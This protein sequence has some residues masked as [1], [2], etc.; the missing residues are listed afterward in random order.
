MRRFQFAI[1]VGMLAVLLSANPARAAEMLVEAE[2]LKDLGGW[3]VDQQFI[4]A[5]GSSY[6][7]AHGLGKPC[8]AAKGTVSLPEPG[9]YRVWVRTKDWVAE[10]EWAPGQFRIAINGKLLDETFGTKGDGAWIWQDGG[11]VDIAARDVT[12]ELRDLTGF[13]GR[14]D[15]IYF[16][17][18]PATR[19][20]EKAGREMTAWRERLLGLKQPPASAGQFDVVV[21]GGGLAGCSAALT[22]ARLGCKVALVQNRPVLGGNNSPEI[23]VHTGPWGAPASSSRRSWAATTAIAQPTSSGGILRPAQSNKPSASGKRSS[24][25]RRTSRSSS[26]GTSS[27][28]RR[29]ATRSP[30]LMP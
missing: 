17:T 5:M 8:A 26:A 29:K 20:P 2:S 23:R 12:L 25:A 22:A 11:M 7:L 14:C 1:S 4:D 9:R 15:A 13:N 24:T 19:P 16:T 27:V 28:R 21:V 10:P 6:L 30:A 3:V 18:D